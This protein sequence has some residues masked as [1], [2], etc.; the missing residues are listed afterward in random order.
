MRYAPI[1]L[2]DKPV[3]V[4]LGI[5]LRIPAAHVPKR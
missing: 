3:R 1:V 5:P 2:D 4:N